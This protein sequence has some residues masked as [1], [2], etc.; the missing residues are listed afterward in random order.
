[1]TGHAN[2]PLTWGRRAGKTVVPAKSA[3]L[4]LGL[5]AGWLIGAF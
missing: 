4:P 1:M 5:D 3:S 2:H